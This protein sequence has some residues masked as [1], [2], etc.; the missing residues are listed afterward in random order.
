VAIGRPC[1]HLQTRPA[2]SISDPSCQVSEE[3]RLRESV[4]WLVQR[5]RD[6]ACE[7]AAKVGPEE[8]D[9]FRALCMILQ[10]ERLQ[11]RVFDL[12][13][14]G[15][16]SAEE[17]VESVFNRYQEQLQNAQ[18]DYLRARSEDV[19]DIRRELLNRLRAAIP[20]CQCRDMAFCE[21]G[22]CPLGNDHITTAAE[23]TPRVVI[24]A[25]VHTTGVLTQD[26]GVNS[27]G[28][29]LARALRLPAVS[30]IRD[31][32][33]QIPP[34]ADLLVNGDTGD[35][36]VNPSPETISQMKRQAGRYRRDLAV[37]PP[38][39]G[40]R[41]LATLDT[42]QGI[43]AALEVRA[44]GIGL[45]RTEMEA[46][47]AGRLLTEEE[48]ESQYAAVVRAMAPNPV[49][50]RL[51]DFGDDK[52]LACKDMPA[53]HGAVSGFRGAQYLLAHP[54]LL[55]SQAR[56][57]ARASVYGTI[58]VT[59]PMISD[60]EQFQ[61]LRHEFEQ[62]VADLPSRALLHGVMLEIPSA[63]LQ[64]GRLLEEADFGC[65]GTN[66]LVQYLFG[67]SRTDQGTSNRAWCEHPVLWNLMEA[68]VE[69]SRE[70]GTPLSVCGELACEP[71]FVSRAMRVGINTISTGPGDIAGIRRSLVRH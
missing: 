40:L 67:Q 49:Y 14:V 63:C 20:H 23:L 30:G 11:A 16:L 54:E 4:V 50:I 42:T 66:D 37:Y 68:M 51:F 44:E 61:R 46:L 70:T 28:A 39:A 1:L 13:K 22:Y 7:A 10:D 34:D 27:H 31:L 15:G 19:A 56:A 36:I 33:G 6:L 25:D 8:A 58:R 53:P 69:A 47:R 59:Y 55:K 45:Y 2:E 48:Q 65:V 26:G 64:V 38:V 62:A 5:L 57:L 32:Y 9:I 43:D 12:I 24:E 60:V 17:A 3:T 35:V 21:I 29:I 18:S 52:T 41:V 71:R